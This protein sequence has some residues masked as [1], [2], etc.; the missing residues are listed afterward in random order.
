[1]FID[2]T[3]FAFGKIFS[4][5]CTNEEIYQMSGK[6][7]VMPVLSG[8]GNST[9][10]MYGQ[11]GTGKTYTM[12]AIQDQMIADIFS[13]PAIK[14][15][16]VQ[17]NICCFEI[18]GK[19]CY[20][21]LNRKEEVFLREG[22]DK[23]IHVRG[24]TY[25]PINKPSELVEYIESARS[26]RTTSSTKMNEQSSRTHA[27]VRIV[28]DYKEW[29]QP[30]SLTMVDLAGSEMSGDSMYHTAEQRREGKESFIYRS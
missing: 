7:L 25:F 19:K 16:H 5:E 14:K 17:I 15:G 27:I 4:T 11:T 2:T 9:L 8:K 20:D 22:D 26:E 30:Y 6:N 10:I 29:A 21:L 18:S 28:F 1:M 3:T 24:I 23:K 12:S 13:I